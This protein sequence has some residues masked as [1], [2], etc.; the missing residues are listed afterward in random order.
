MHLVCFHIEIDIDFLFDMQV[1]AGCRN[2]GFLQSVENNR[3]IHILGFDNTLK[4]FEQVNFRFVFHNMTFLLY[5]YIHF[6]HQHF[7]TGHHDIASV[8]LEGERQIF[9]VRSLE[10][11]S[12]RLTGTT[13]HS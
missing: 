3:V 8:P 12:H 1:L 10:L 6:R 11:A 5:L 2:Q 13:R 7:G 4:H 9:F